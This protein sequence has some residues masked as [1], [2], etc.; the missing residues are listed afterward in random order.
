RPQTSKSVRAELRA[1]NDA[2]G[3]PPPR[4]QV[5]ILLRVRR[6]RTI[7]VEDD[8]HISEG[9]ETA[10]LRVAFKEGEPVADTP[11]NGQRL[12]FAAKQFGAQ[13]V[14]ERQNPASARCRRVGYAP[15]VDARD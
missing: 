2:V 13:V 10:P 1:V 3:N 5:E 8:S 7:C 4:H 6:V 11:P 14:I 12:R 15:D 9:R